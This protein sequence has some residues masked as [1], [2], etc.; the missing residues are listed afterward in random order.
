MRGVFAMK[1][2]MPALLPGAYGSLD[3]SFFMDELIDASAALEVYVEKIKFSKVESDWFLPIIQQKEALSS[4]K[5]EGTQATLDGVLINQITPNDE[6]K[7]LNEI[8]NYLSASAVGYQRLKRGEFDNEL[9]LEIHRELL[10]GNVRR[11][12]ETVGEYRTHQNYI[13]RN[14][15]ELVYTPPKPEYV[16][17]LMNNLISYINSD[18]DK[19]R[20]LIR[21]A[22]I[23]AQFETIH[24][25]GDG[26]GRVGRILIPLYLYAKGQIPMPFFFISEALERDKHKYYKLLMDTREP[27]R[28]NEW[29]KFFLETVSK[30]CRKYIEIFNKINDLYEDTVHKACDLIKSSSAVS[31]VNTLFRYPVLDSKTMQQETDISLATINRYMNILLKNN[32]LYTDGKQRNRHFFFYD[33]ISLIRD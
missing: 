33:L 23:H 16:P 8:V 4:S 20:Y 12:T 10:S 11:N 17:E 29:I 31:I 25:F 13:G 2:Y 32:I 6:D 3:Y 5:L 14:D 19:Y 18:A 28:W 1:A 26:N 27:Q 30:Q 24:P 9:F 7:N 15:G 22:I 21:I